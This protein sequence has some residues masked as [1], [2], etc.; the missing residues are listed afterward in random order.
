MPTDLLSVGVISIATNGYSK[1]WKDLVVSAD[2]NLPKDADVRFH[3]FT[4]EVDECREFSSRFSTRKFQ[5]YK[6]ES[7]GWPEATLHRYRIY[8]EHRESLTEEVLMHLD[9]DMLIEQNFLNEIF[10]R[11]LT[12][13]MGL[14]L[15]PGYFRPKGF[16]K[17]TY[18]FSNKIAFIRDLRLRMRIGGLG[19][20]EIRQ[21]SQAFVMRKRRKRYFCGGIWF[22]KR[23]EF[24]SLVQELESQERIDSAN[25]VTAMWHD[26]SYLNK[27][28]TESE[29]STFS[30]SL[31]FEKSYKNLVGIS[32]IITAVNKHLIEN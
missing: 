4:D 11:P 23:E 20:W 25:G 6:I 3:L 2:K 22:G 5:F 19:A 14:V 16:D 30:P 15:H 27:W 12:A 9:S 31:C 29:F 26:E 1:Y 7:L 28:A 32:N 13:G 10:S 17:Y 18:Y 21:K 24:L 8:S